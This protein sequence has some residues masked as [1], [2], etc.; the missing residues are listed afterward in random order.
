MSKPGKKEEKNLGEMTQAVEEKLREGQVPQARRELTAA[1]DSWRDALPEPPLR[2]PVK[3]VK[4]SSSAA[5]ELL[6]RSLKS[7]GR[8]PL[9]LEKRE[10]GVAIVTARGKKLQIGFLPQGE[11]NMLLEFDP[12]LRIFRPRLLDIGR[13][14]DGSVSSVAVELVRP[15]RH[16]CP[17]CGNLHSG[18]HQMCSKCRKRK[19]PQADKEVGGL[20]VPVQDAIDAILAEAG[21]EDLPV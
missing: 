2:F 18:T 11:V 15:E 14:E 1:S 17:E 6:R 16:R 12:K 5:T 8:P 10:D 20:P 21:D 13:E 3:L 7:R 4:L 19:K 9:K